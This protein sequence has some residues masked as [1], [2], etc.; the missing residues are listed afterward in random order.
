[1]SKGKMHGSVINL[2]RSATVSKGKHMRVPIANVMPTCCAAYVML[3]VACAD[4][5]NVRAT[6]VHYGGGA[7]QS[8]LRW[9]WPTCAP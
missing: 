8:G 4:L 7:G 2:C 9:G 3:A 1:M 6:C 5:K